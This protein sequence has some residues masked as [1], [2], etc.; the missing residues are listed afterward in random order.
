MRMSANVAHVSAAARVHNRSRQKLENAASGSGQFPRTGYRATSSPIP[1]R[2][3]ECHSQVRPRAPVAEAVLAHHGFALLLRDPAW[4]QPVPRSGRCRLP[5]G[6]RGLTFCRRSRVAASG[7]TLA[8]GSRTGASR[9]HP[10]RN[11]LIPRTLASLI[12]DFSVR[13]IQK[14]RLSPG[15]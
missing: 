11:R 5:A 4:L 7:G 14:P 2:D 6:T 1:G 8:S 12:R 3:D 15:L 13:K 10:H 9:C